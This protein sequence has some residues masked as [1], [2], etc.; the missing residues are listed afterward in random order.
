MSRSSFLRCALWMLFCAIVITSPAQGQYRASLQGVV[1][2]STGAVIPDATIT[3][4]NK[5]TNQ[6]LTTK[7]SGVGNYAFNALA[8]SRY[9]LEAEQT[10]FKKKVLDDVLVRAEQANAL[11]VQLEAGDATVTVNVNASAEAPIDT[12]TGQISGTVNQAQIATLPS[13]GRDVFQLVQLA[14]GVFGDASRGSGGGSFN[15]PGN[16]GPGGPGNTGGIFQTEN[17]PQASAGGGRTDQNNI[18]LDGVSIN[19]VT[20]AG[21]AVVTPTEDSVK[22]LRVVSNSYDAEYGRTSAAQI[23]AISQNGTNEF[24]GSAFIKVDRPGLNAYPRYDPNGTPG[25]WRNC[26]NPGGCIDDR[27]NARFNQIGGSVGGPIWK[28]KLFFFFAYETVRNHSTSTGGGWYE[29]PAID[30]AA[31]SGSIASKFLTFP[32]TGASFSQILESPS[33]RHSCADIGLIQGVNCNFI[34]GQGLD[35]G[36][37]LVGFAPGQIDPSFKPRGSPGFPNGSPGL[38]G[39]GTGN[40]SNLDG[41]ADLFFVATV[42]PFQQVSQQFNGRLDFQVTPN[43]LVAYSIYHVPQETTSFNGPSRASNIFHHNQVNYAQTGFWNHIF[44]PTLLNEARIDGAGW[45]WNEFTSNPQ[46]PYGLPAVQFSS[47]SFGNTIGTIQPAKLGPNFG[48]IFD[49]NTYSIKDTLSKVINS[50]NLK[51]GGEGTKLEYLDDPTWNAQP[52]YFFNNYWDFLNDAPSSENATVDPRTGIPSDFRKDTRQNLY[53]FFAQDDWK[54]RRNLTLNLGLRWEYF[55][56]L[57]EKKGNISNL[58]LGSGASTLSGIRFV[59]GG[60]QVSPPKTNFGPQLGFAWSPG[61]GNNKLVIRG[62]FAIGYSGL[63]AAILT[64]TRF[65]PPFI[66][67]SGTLTGNRI[68]YGTAANIS[69]FGQ[70]PA[71]P[72]LVT[73]FDSNNLPTAPGVSLNVTGIPHDLAT[74]STYRYSLQVEQELARQWVMS[75]GYQGSLGRHLPLQTNLNAL[76]APAVIAGQAAY[77]PRLNFIDWY[78]EGGNSSYNALLTEL[79]HRFASSFEFDAQYRWSKSIDDGSG[80]FTFSDYPWLPGKNRGPSDFDVRNYFK[81]WGLWSPRLFAGKNNL[82]EKTIGGWS[83]SGILNAHSGFPWTPVYSGIGCNAVIPN[84]GQCN[85]RPARYLGGAGDSQGTDIFKQS[86]GNFGN[87]TSS[88]GADGIYFTAPTVSKASGSWPV[89]PAALPTLPGIGR[90]TF[91][92]PHYFDIDAT[93]TKAFGLPNLPVLGENARFEFRANA[94]NLFNKLNLAHVDNNI[95]DPHFGRANTVLGS[96]TVELEAHFR[97]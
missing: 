22:E 41:I 90:N 75:L 52:T 1:T 12:A 63:E 29:T 42:S 86:N 83:I 45:R 28:N 24:H 13:Y 30:K 56:G 64:N 68:V 59:L 40:P 61:Y 93:L 51:F 17:R 84:S 2:D 3:L 6:I 47:T 33:D 69:K 49:Q 97:F 14:P 71:N 81:L 43:D 54:V 48:S 44:S 88:K 91:F 18:T 20:W 7:S 27:N 57:Y 65:N 89:S 25:N 10:G 79:R 39:D 95:T 21:A 70:F 82:L 23:Q 8:P 38:G 34:A 73:S 66:T 76:F 72:N 11:N 74:Q 60:H 53:A 94:Y 78:Y 31:P 58:E 46:T 92:G 62:G 32:G 37:P 19:S 87:A 4:T 5:E 9:K 15:L 80:P 16:Q 55:G 77:N 50:H 35:I 26:K 85:L 96:R 36:R 67:N